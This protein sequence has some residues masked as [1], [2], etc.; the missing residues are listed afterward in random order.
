MEGGI[1]AGCSP[2][3]HVFHAHDDI[4]ALAQEGAVEIHNVVRV[5]LVHDMQL[6]HD[7]ATN[8]LLRLHMYDLCKSAPLQA[9]TGKPPA[10][11]FLAMTVP[12]AICRTLLTVP[13]FPLPSSFSTS[14]SS[15]FR[16]SLY[17]IPISSWAVRPLAASSRAAWSSFEGAGAR[18][19]GAFRAR[20][21]TFLR[22][23]VRTPKPSPD[24]VAGGVGWMRP[25][26]VVCVFGGA[27]LCNGRG[28]EA[29]ERFLYC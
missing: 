25:D 10:L 18:G 22:F 27:A 7:P 28:L 13:P 5:A 24:I 11:T 9:P 3:V 29:V 26:A 1:G 21:F 12:V 8:L 20:P 23:I 2:N 15:R 6:P 19:A 17:S 4:V 14:R 16:S